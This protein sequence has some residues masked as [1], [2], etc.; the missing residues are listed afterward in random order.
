MALHDPQR[1][2]PIAHRRRKLRRSRSARLAAGE[3]ARE[4]R[5]A[6]IAY[7]IL[8][9]CTDPHDLASR[10]GVGA[11]TIA[12]DIDELQARWASQQIASADQHRAREIRRLEA[13]IQE[14]WKGWDRS[15]EDCTTTTTTFTEEKG[16]ETTVTVKG[17]AGDPRFLS[18]M[19]DASSQILDIRGLR[20]QKIAN[21]NPEGGE[22]ALE[23]V[24]KV[25][26]Q[27]VESIGD[28]AQV[29][30]GQAVRHA[31]LGQQDL[32]SQPPALELQGDEPLVLDAEAIERAVDG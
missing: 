13:V 3:Q 25:L 18:I 24:M 23:G 7:E 31:V 11:G 28:G 22:T 27:A 5:L 32:P 10:Y 12:R 19:A 6:S 20:V 8:R 14:S 26:L 15:R 29:I 2:L 1:T 9:G 17:Q 30:D 4:Q 21:T 16:E